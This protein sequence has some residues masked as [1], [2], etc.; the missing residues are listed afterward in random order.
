MI[1]SM[2]Y[3]HTSSWEHFYQISECYHYQCHNVTYRMSLWQL[4]IHVPRFAFMAYFGMISRSVCFRFWLF[5]YCI[6]SE[7]IKQ[8]CPKIFCIWNLVAV[9][10][11]WPQ[12]DQ[13][14]KKRKNGGFTLL[15]QGR[16]V[17]L[18]PLPDTR[19]VPKCLMYNILP[20]RPQKTGR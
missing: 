9:T 1:P 17:G 10:L 19:I 7:R 16:W 3:P 5:K 13:K 2:Q 11:E 8:I 20:S 18:G 12:N 15:T 6:T 4:Y 14:V